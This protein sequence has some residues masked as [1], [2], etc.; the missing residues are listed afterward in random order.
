MSTKLTKWLDGAQLMDRWSID[1]FDFK[2][3]I[4]DKGLKTYDTYEY[5]SYPQSFVNKGFPRY[6]PE[7]VKKFLDYVS[8]FPTN[9][10]KNH[11]RQFRFKLKDVEKFEKKHPGLKVKISETFKDEISKTL[12]DF[13]EDEKESQKSLKKSVK[14]T[15]RPP[16]I[17]KEMLFDLVEKFQKIERNPNT[18][19]TQILQEH[20]NKHNISETTTRKFIRSNKRYLPKESK[21][22]KLHELTKEDIKTLFLNRNKQS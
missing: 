2:E 4:C 3:L 19:E 11:M 8:N 15:G 12:N 17:T 18:T 5:E 7:R 1:A 20:A 9:I 13:S 6:V 21:N 16:I 22:K 10:Q 14:P